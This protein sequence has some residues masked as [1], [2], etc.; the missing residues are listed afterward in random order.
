[1]SFAPI[2]LFVYNRPWH[3]SQVIKSLQA[4]NESF[5]SVLYIYSDAPKTPSAI[6]D[7]E[8]VR[9]IIHNISGFESIFIVERETNFGLAKSIINGVT[10]LCHEYGSVIVLEDD[11]VTSPNFLNYMNN[12]LLEYKNE[13]NVMQIAGYMFPME[14]DVKEDTLFLP[15]IS[16][17]GWATWDRAWECFD[18]DASGFNKLKNDAELRCKFDLDGNYSYF[19][20]LCAQQMGKTDSWA[21]RWYL[22][23]FLFEGLT[24]YPR[25]SLVAN[26]G[27]DGSGVNC[28]V[29]DIE[30]SGLDNDFSVHSYPKVVEVS[31]LKHI[32]LENMPRPSLSITSIFNRVLGR[33]KQF[34]N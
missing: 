33:F 28:A 25:K 21:I 29:S 27:F 13:E 1:M 23:V 10:Q 15:F 24:L 3:T 16:S 32:V 22:S 26:T 14:L 9:K 11:L 20:M 4:N 6:K 5:E 34:F 30:V 8:E 7:V 12:A 31:S 17:W 2:A 18:E 19:K